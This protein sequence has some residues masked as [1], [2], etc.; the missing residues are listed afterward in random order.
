MTFYDGFI[1]GIGVLAAIV[2]A[3]VTWTFICGFLKG[4]IAGRVLREQFRQE[5]MANQIKREQ[6]IDDKQDGQELH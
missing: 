1:F 4:F 2:A 6:I 3:W 5:K